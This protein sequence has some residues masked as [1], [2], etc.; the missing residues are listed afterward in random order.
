MIIENSS[1]EDGKILKLKD[2][3]EKCTCEIKL[4]IRYQLFI[5]I[6]KHNLC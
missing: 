2:L 3:G 1:T 5:I 6:L 4:V